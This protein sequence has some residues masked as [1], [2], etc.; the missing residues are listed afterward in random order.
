MVNEFGDFQTPPALVAAV[1]KYLYTGGKVWERVLEPC[2]GQGNFI[3]GLLALDTK[4]REIQGIEVQ[5]EYVSM[6]EELAETSCVVKTVIKQAN[7]FSL[8]FQQDLDWSGGGNLLVI[9]NPPWITNAA[10]GALDSANLPTKLN[11]KG[12]SGFEALTGSS[13]FDLAEYIWLKIMTEL[14]LQQPT[15]ALLC[16]TTV[17]RNVLE[18]AARVA[19]P[20]SYASIRKINSKKWFGAAVDACLFHV[21]LRLGQHNYKAEVFSDLET[22]RPENTIGVLNGHLVANVTAYERS[23]YANGKSSIIWRQGIKHDAAKVMELTYDDKGYRNQLGEPV[24]VEP[25][26]VYPLIK[27]TQ[28]FHQSTFNPTK[29]VIVPQ[30]KLKEDTRFLEHLAPQLWQYLTAHSAM[31]EQRK[32]SIYNKQPPFSIFGV[33]DY[34]FSPY[35]VAI[36]GFHKLP[37]FKAVGLS[38]KRPVMFDDTCYFTAC[39]SP[40]RAAFLSSLLNHPLCLELISSLAFLDAK[41]PITK[42]ILQRLDLKALL[43]HIQPEE[44]LEGFNTELQQLDLPFDNIENLYLLEQEI[45]QFMDDR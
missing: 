27:S 20:I 7:I 31:F 6:A 33:G 3:S 17:A 45:N 38:Q 25:D 28:L 40:R 10:L 15:I 42:K 4:P 9:G 35:K 29:A 5:P 39:N 34:S 14:A 26:Y 1:L 13:N 24:V 2:C 43:G 32:S 23:A 30:L 19:L 12:L 21:E 18:F 36:S 16:K 37:R 44:L 22:A 8:D 11:L 41:R